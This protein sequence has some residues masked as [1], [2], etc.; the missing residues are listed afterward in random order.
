MYTR[1]PA[2]HMLQGTAPVEPFASSCE[3]AYERLVGTKGNLDSIQ[4]PSHTW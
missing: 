1:T 3:A 2:E 4:K